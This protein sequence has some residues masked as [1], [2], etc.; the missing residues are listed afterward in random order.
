MQSQEDSVQPKINTLKNKQQYCSSSLA[1]MM[2]ELGKPSPWG[3]LRTQSSDCTR[4]A[5][6]CSDT[7][8]ILDAHTALDCS[9]R[10]LP[11]ASLFALYSNSMKR[12]YRRR[13]ES[14]ERCP[15][16]A[17]LN[18]EPGLRSPTLQADSLPA[19]PPGKPKNTGVGSLSLLQGIFLIQ[20]SNQGLLHCRWIFHRLSYQLN[21]KM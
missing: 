9:P 13:N 21:P 18:T 12:F 2:A 6:P 4:M 10:A 19:K 20:E 14:S 17:C 1:V 5:A 11:D 15:K 7:E 16:S 8:T 3:F